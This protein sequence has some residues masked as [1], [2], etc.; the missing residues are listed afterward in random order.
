MSIAPVLAETPSTRNR[1]PKSET[2]KAIAPAKVLH[3]IEQH[4]SPISDSRDINGLI[5]IRFNGSTIERFNGGAAITVY[6]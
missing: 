2:E 6:P 1:R 4:V 5:P 3:T